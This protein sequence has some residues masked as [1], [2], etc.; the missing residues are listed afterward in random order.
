MSGNPALS[1][2][3]C[4]PLGP[5]MQAIWTDRDHAWC[6]RDQWV[7]RYNYSS[8][9][10]QRV[11]RLPARSDGWAARLKDAIARSRFKQW[12][13]PGMD[14][15]TLAEL[16]NGDLVVLFDRVYWY[17]PRLHDR[18]AEALPHDGIDPPIAMPLR[19]G[20]AV[21][22]LSGN[23]YFGEYLNGHQRDIRVARVDMQHRRVD[24]CWTFPRSDIKHVH[25]IHYDPFR[26]RLWI[27][28][29][30]LDHESALWFTDDEFLTVQRF[31]GGDQSWRAIAM[32]FDA[33][34]MEWGM[35]AGQDAPAD[36]VNRIY[37][38]DFASGQRSERAV[39][40]NPVYAACAFGDGAAIMQ[41]SFE[42]RRRQPTPETV[43]LW[44]RHPDGDWSSLFSLSYCARPQDGVG[45]YG[46]LL[47]PQGVA[48][49]GQL[50][51]T[52]VNTARHAGRL[53][54]LRWNA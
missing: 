11:F 50:L 40:G 47:I 7:Y 38:H 23:A 44:Y 8:R 19:G 30:D 46:H 54:H 14:I 22:P 51:C 4:E 15:D 41:T 39:V 17:S 36:A 33:G 28:T 13:R 26:N 20:L 37:R 49:A 43:S 6:A 10:M 27:C 48:P 52:P 42:P 45:P 25:A 18:T 24:I 32:L 9:T 35:D 29:G 12:L 53:L 16:P 3:V 31:G 2:P 1:P 5:R 21:H 34:G